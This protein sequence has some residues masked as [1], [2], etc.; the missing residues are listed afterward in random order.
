MEVEWRSADGMMKLLVDWFQAKMIAAIPL[1]MQQSQCRLVQMVELGFF[2]QC[3]MLL[4]FME[5]GGLN[6][7]PKWVIPSLSL[8]Q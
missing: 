5:L 1:K 2:L 7:G 8:R 3:F 6:E 4:C